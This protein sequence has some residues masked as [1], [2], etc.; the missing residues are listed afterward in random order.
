MVSSSIVNT[1]VDHELVVVTPVLDDQPSLINLIN[2]L[3]VSTG[4]FHIVVVDD[5]S[6]N[7]PVDLQSI[8]SSR[9]TWTVI[10]LR[11]NT[12]PQRAIAVGLNYVHKN[13][14]FKNV[15]VMDSDGEDNPLTVPKLLE[16]SEAISPTPD[17]AVV[18]RE[19]R[20]N[21]FLFKFFYWLYKIFFWLYTGQAMNFGHYSLLSERAV[22]RIVTYPQLWIHLGTTYLLSRLPI[23]RCP[24]DRGSRYVGKSKTSFISL[25]S[26][27]LRS[28]VAYSEVVIARV[29]A[30]SSVLFLLT[31]GAVAIGAT[32]KSTLWFTVASL[33]F[34]TL[35][36]IATSTILIMLM[37]V[38]R[39]SG[40][41]DSYNFQTLID[42]VTKNY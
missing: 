2:Q 28:I 35:V 4:R 14:T 29:V 37:S 21:S 39:N 20:D 1:S 42:N 13:F 5:G 18:T 41:Y 9:V 10:E 38:S 8:D 26:H 36:F 32:F 15:I 34:L 24:L 6:V 17:I 27:G 16:F 40:E 19:N 11:R 30:L 23:H 22:S 31:I 7:D 3:I 25:V 33:V 12:G